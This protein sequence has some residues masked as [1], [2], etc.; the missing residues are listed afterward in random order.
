MTPPR[1]APTPAM[2][3]RE[4][5]AAINRLYIARQS[6]DDANRDRDA[7][8]REVTRLRASGSGTTTAG[9]PEMVSVADLKG[10]WAWSWS[11]PDWDISPAAH[12]DR[13]LAAALLSSPP[14]PSEARD[15]SG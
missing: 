7:L 13:A 8:L 5:I 2:T 11:Q 1:E 4:M 15:S 14:G 3:E 10:A 12:F 6:D 9:A